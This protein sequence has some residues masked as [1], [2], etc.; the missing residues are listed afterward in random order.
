MRPGTRKEPPASLDCESGLDGV[1]MTPGVWL[2]SGTPKRKGERK[3]G[4]V[5]ISRSNS[6]SC[7]ECACIRG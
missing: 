3:F 6:E 1:S 7:S 4:L 2:D 5:R